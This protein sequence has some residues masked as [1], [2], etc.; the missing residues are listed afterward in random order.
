VQNT[1]PIILIAAIGKNN[2][3]G[4]NNDLMW[5]LKSD[6]DFFKSTTSGH[7]V[8]MGRK[9]WESL[10]A[11]FRPL[12]N[13]VNCVVTR[14]SDF[15]AEGA[16]LFASLHAA[17]E[18]AREKGAKKVFIIG[19][20]QIYAECLKSNLIDEMYLTHVAGAFSEADVFFPEVDPLQWNTTLIAA[21]EA[22]DKNQFA[23]EILHYVLREV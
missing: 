7:W 22:D 4:K 1:S 11:R 13:R 14:N 8:I 2:E 16:H 20:A 6:M 9:S 3:L 15:Q 10:P 18:K 21:F 23:G 19:G 12:P 17:I 5:R